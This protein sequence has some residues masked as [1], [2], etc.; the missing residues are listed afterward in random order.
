MSA[1]GVTLTAEDWQRFTALLCLVRAGGGVGPSYDELAAA[2]G[3]HSRASASRML[4]RLEAAGLIHRPRYL[5]RA[6]VVTR[7]LVP[8]ATPAGAVLLPMA[9]TLH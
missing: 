9:E 3:L 2:W 5:A 8:V 7:C 4:D 1:A 6:I